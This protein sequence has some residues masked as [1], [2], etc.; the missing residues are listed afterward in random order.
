M[1]DELWGVPFGRWDVCRI[2]PGLR[3][4]SG[5]FAYVEH[6]GF[7]RWARA[8]A[9]RIRLEPSAAEANKLIMAFRCPSEVEGIFIRLPADSEKPR[10]H[11]T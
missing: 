3:S 11:R 1:T 5:H 8:V 7:A 9:E 10:R 6:L 2:G 4:G